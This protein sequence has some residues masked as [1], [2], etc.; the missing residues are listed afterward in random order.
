MH[1]FGFQRRRLLPLIDAEV[2]RVTAQMA[3]V[4]FDDAGGD[5]IEKAPVVGDEQHAAGERQQHL[6]QPLDGSDVEMVG[7]LVQQQQL[8]REHQRPRQR[9]ALLQPAGQVRYQPLGV[10]LQARERGRDLVLEA[11]AVARIEFFLQLVQPLHQGG[12]GG[13]AGVMR[14]GE[15]V[16]RGMI[17]D[18]QP[19]TLTQPFSHRFE[20]AQAGLECGLLGYA[21]QLQRRRAPQFAVIRGGSAVNE[22]QQARLAGAVAAD[23]TDAFARL[24]HQIDVIEQRHVTVRQGNLGELNQGH[25]QP[26]AETGICP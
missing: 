5:I 26:E 16:R 17:V 25:V 6:F 3:A 13:R 24:D 20:H 22:P 10:E 18:E 9:D 4:E 2:A 1:G 19:G 11:P 8:R 7:R 12:I 14:Y 21:R 15:G 23:Q